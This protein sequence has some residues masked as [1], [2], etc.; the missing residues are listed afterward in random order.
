M[1]RNS[2]PEAGCATTADDTC[3]SRRSNVRCVV[4]A[5][6]VIVTPLGSAEGRSVMERIEL[7]MDNIAKAHQVDAGRLSLCRAKSDDRLFVRY[8][9]TI[10]AELQE[11]EDGRF[12]IFPFEQR[13]PV[14]PSFSESSLQA[15]VSEVDRRHFSGK[16]RGLVPRLE[17]GCWSMECATW[18][19]S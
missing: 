17:S 2:G 9:P 6:S 15:A 11:G 5:S 10:L 16:I 3:Q 4:A 14:G 13:G 8:G 18:K 7:D 12:V 19:P 1:A